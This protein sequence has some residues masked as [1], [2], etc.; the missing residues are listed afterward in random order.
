MLIDQRFLFQGSSGDSPRRWWDLRNPRSWAPKEE[1]TGTGTFNRGQKVRTRGF[2]LWGERRKWVVNVNISNGGLRDWV[3]SFI[4][5]MFCVPFLRL[6]SELCR[7]RKSSLCIEQRHLNAIWRYFTFSCVQVVKGGAA[8][9]D[10]RLVQGDQILCVNGHDL[11][12]S[13]QE[14]AAPVLK[15]AQGKLVMQVRRLKVGNR[16]HQQQ[17]QQQHQQGDG[18]SA[19][20][21]GPGRYV[22][23]AITTSHILT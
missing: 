20:R 9:A 11:T 19:Q 23:H 6:K 13:S 16:K 2:Y 14:Q 10:G 3:R 22:L 12:E 7:A 4:W 21:S 8:D 15:M 17:Q 18:A 1:R 5:C